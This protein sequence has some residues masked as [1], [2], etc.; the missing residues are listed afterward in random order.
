MAERLWS[1]DKDYDLINVIQESYVRWL[2]DVAAERG[3]PSANLWDMFSAMEL[4]RRRE[5]SLDGIHLN[6]EGHRIMADFMAE[7]LQA[8]NLTEGVSIINGRVEC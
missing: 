5:L 4:S 6:A 8:Y 7:L 2:Q 1:P 3:L